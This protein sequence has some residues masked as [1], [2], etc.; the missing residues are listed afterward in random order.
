M[1]H[2]TELRAKCAHHLLGSGVVRKSQMVGKAAQGVAE[3]QPSRGMVS[4][5]GT[6]VVVDHSRPRR[7]WG[8]HGHGGKKLRSQQKQT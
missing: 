8:R 1:D 7:G 2:C 6:G 3:P 4:V 5:A